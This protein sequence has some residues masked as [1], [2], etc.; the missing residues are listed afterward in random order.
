MMIMLQP[1]MVLKAY[2]LCRK[3][4]FF[5]D[6]VCKL[7]FLLMPRENENYLKIKLNYE[8]KIFEILNII[9]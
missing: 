6:F 5:Y 4:C 1:K 3:K 8:S 9:Y 2:K 7:L